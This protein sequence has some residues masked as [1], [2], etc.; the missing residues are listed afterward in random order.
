MKNKK[1]ESFLYRRLQWEDLDTGYLRHLAELARD[2]DCEGVGLRA[3]DSLIKGDATSQALFQTDKKGSAQLIGRE[4][5]AVCGLKLIPILLATYDEQLTFHTDH[6][7]GDLL[8][9]GCC[10]G[11]V[12]GPVGSL[13]TAERVFLNF[14]Q[15]LS[16]ISTLTQSFVRALEPSSTKLLDTRKTHPGYRM[17]IKYAVAC[18]GGWN[19]RLGLYDR[20]MIKDNHLAFSGATGGTRLTDAILQ[21]RNKRPDLPI[22]VE[23]DGLDQLESVLAA[24]PDVILL[25]NFT[26]NEIKDAL[27][28]IDDEAWTEASGQI[29]LGNIGQYADLGLDFISTGS[30]VHQS[31]WVD[32]GLDWNS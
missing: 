19:H 16:G 7:D 24:K 17:L 14:I 6:Q 11:I 10:L 4:P 27:S 28:I 13:L 21:A 29:N 20:I 5:M 22:E 8:E 25:D 1:W 18:G 26:A 3:T 2:E 23:V 15:F 12:T 31:Q 9:A 30:T 32:I